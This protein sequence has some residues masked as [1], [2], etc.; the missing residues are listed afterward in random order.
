MSPPYEGDSNNV[1]IPGLKGTNSAPGNAQGVVGVSTNG[2]GVH[3]ETTG[4]VAAVAAFN[5]APGAGQG[6]WAH[7]DQGEGMHGE[8][9]GN[10][11]AVAAW[12]VAPGNGPGLFAH[13]DNGE[14]IRAENK[15]NL[16]AVA[17]FNLAPGQGQ[18]VWAHSDQG[19]GIHG[20]TKGNFAAVA[21]FNLAP[22]QGQGVW[23]HSDQGEGVHAENNS[24]LF[25]AVYGENKGPGP[26]GFF[27]G[28][29]VVT[30][31]IT[32]PIGMDCAEEFDI[33]EIPLVVP[34]T[35]MVIDQDGRL[36]PSNCPYDKKVAGV[37]SG[38]GDCK[39][40]IILGRQEPRDSKMP[41]ALVGKVYCKV[42]AA[43][44]PIEVGDLLT[45]SPTRGHAMK[46]ADQVKAFGAVIGKALRPMENGQGLIPILVALQ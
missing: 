34:G 15:S 6:V 28:N 7:S 39:P 38:A 44:S 27:R 37:I 23:A 20:E 3:G 24:N 13:S 5:L 4:N 12:N 40:G 45:T 9:K 19:E 8:T 10:A 30:G 21:A 32:L 25:A 43:Y 33:S 41:V 16:A 14:G 31:D 1:N 29:V 2:E 22:G 26:A 11:A 36:Q 17:A 46:A 42:D 18:G 35:V